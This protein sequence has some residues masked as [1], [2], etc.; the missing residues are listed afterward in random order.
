[1]TMDLQRLAVLEQRIAS[2]EAAAAHAPASVADVGQAVTVFAPYSGSNGDAVKL[3]S[4]TWTAALDAD[5]ISG[6]LGVVVGL[7]GGW[8]EIQIAGPRAADGTAGATYYAPASAG[9]P[10]ASDP[11]NGVII[12]RQISPGLRLV[13]G[14]GGGGGGFPIDEESPNGD[15]RIQADIAD[16]GSQVRISHSCGSEVKI[17]MDGSGVGIMRVLD[18]TGAGY[19]FDKN[20]VTQVQVT[21][22][23]ATGEETETPV[24]SPMSQITVQACVNGVNKTLHLFGYVE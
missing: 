16:S 12:E 15:L 13:G 19:K 2:L 9:P 14:G 4:G 20:G 23:P 21:T 10:S 1:M 17:S 11:G 24:G 7:S 6:P 18:C 5:A 8:A 3:A 22:D